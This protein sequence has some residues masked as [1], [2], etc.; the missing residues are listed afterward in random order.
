V[1]ATSVAA[2]Q[3]LFVSMVGCSPV[4]FDMPRHSA[5]LNGVS[6]T[7]IEIRAPSFDRLRRHDAR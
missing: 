7:A 4:E 1:N 2:Q 6:A 5:C 3:S